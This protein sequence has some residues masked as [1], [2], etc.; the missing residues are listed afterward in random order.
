MR[1]LLAIAGCACC[2]LFAGCADSDSTSS[3]TTEVK[4]SSSETVKTLPDDYSAED[5]FSTDC[6]NGDDQLDSITIRKD[7]NYSECDLTGEKL[8]EML[9]V[10]NDLSDLALLR[11]D[12]SGADLSGQSLSNAD[13]TGAN[14]SGANL[15][16]ADLSDAFLESANLTGANLTGANL[17]VAYLDRA[18]LTGANFT[19][20]NFTNADLS[21]ADLTDANL[22]GAIWWNTLCPGSSNVEGENG[23]QE[24]CTA[25]K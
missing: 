9:A 11:A 19:N 13:L 7:A 4:E 21:G 14:L 22:T 23:Q 2:L 5:L 12:L 16:G 18:N 3:D 1:H 8:N 10:T 20:A 15:A 6:V 17:S 24:P 25:A